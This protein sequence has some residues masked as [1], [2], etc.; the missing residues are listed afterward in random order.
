MGNP[1]AAPR[2]SGKRN[3][4]ALSGLLIALGVSSI[5]VSAQAA[6]VANVDDARIIENAKT[7]KEWLSNGLGYGV[8]R[9]SPLDQINAANVGKL[10]LAW[11]YP[12]E[13]DPRRRS[14]PDRRRRD[15]V[16]HGSLEHR[17]AINAKTGEKIWTFDSQSPHEQGYGCAAMSSIAA[18]RS[19]RARCM[20]ARPTR[21]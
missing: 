8:N 11:S 10:G 18:S 3:G 19:T 17:Y 21:A 6:D 14:D 20:S 1:S 12:L 2:A 5:I 16:C 15:H 7:G 4:R 13:L 9:F